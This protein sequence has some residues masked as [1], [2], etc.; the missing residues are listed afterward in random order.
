MFTVIETSVFIKYSKEVWTDEERIEFITWI[1]N[2][3]LAGD[4]IP[5]T[6]GCRKVRWVRQ[7]A[8]KRGGARVIYYNQLEKGNIGLLIVYAKAKF[9]NLPSEFLEQLR[10]EFEK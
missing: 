6:G 3:P 1:A 4:V 8:G 9:D 2:N 10:K 7:G 5:R